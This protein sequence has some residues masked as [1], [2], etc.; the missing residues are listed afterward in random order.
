[1]RRERGTAGVTL[2]EVLVAVTLLSLLSVGML[3]ALRLGLSALCQDRF[4]A[5]GQPPGG[6]GA[7]HSGAGAAGPH[8]GAGEVPGRGWR[9]DAYFQGG[10]QT[11]RLV[12]VFSLEQ[13]WRGQP[14]VLE[15]F[16]IPGENGEGVR[17]VVN[18]APYNGPAGMEP[19]LYRDG[20]GES[21]LVR[22]GRQAGLLPVH[23]SGPGAQPGGPGHLGARVGSSGV[24]VRHPGGDGADGS[25]PVAI[26]AD[27]R[28][29]AG[30][31]VPEGGAVCGLGGG[32]AR[33]PWRRPPACAGSGHSRHPFK[34]QGAESAGQRAADGA[35]GL[36]R[37]WRPSGSRWRERCAG[38]RS[39]PPPRWTTCAATTWRWGRCS[40]RNWNWPGRWCS[41]TSARSRRA[42]PSSITSF[43]AASR[44]WTSFRRPPSWM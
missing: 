27:H 26:A 2:I 35:C 5:D 28:D 41:R 15:L 17:L 34:H 18:E 38:R 42:R 37:R 29:G 44:T 10:P 25:E 6:G 1:M 7:A 11:M 8:A 43:P 20:G 39:A 22:P 13:A 33:A 3:Y 31:H 14:K 40:G 12:S 36:R 32:A 21:A 23:V 30:L 19:V 4:Q 24:A 9:R 16:V